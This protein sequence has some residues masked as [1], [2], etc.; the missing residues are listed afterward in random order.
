[1]DLIKASKNG[2]IEKIK[3]L[4]K[5]G[6]DINLQTNNGSTALMLASRYE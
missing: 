1:M 2:N 5:A 6:V 3:E 4:L